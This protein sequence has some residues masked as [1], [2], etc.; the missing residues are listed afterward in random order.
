[1]RDELIKIV[2]EV[3]SSD[4]PLNSQLMVQ[5]ILDYFRANPIAVVVKVEEGAAIQSIISPYVDVS[6]I[7]N[8]QMDGD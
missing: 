8:S 6:F 7:Y 2:E 3:H 5:S 1:M 4:D